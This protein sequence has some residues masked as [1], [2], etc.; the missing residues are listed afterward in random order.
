MGDEL[1]EL[2]GLD[3]V[4]ESQSDVARHLNGLV[5][6]DQRRHG[7]DAAVAGCQAWTLPQ[8]LLDR[9]SGV[10]LERRGYRP[11][12]IKGY[13]GRWGGRHRGAFRLIGVGQWRAK[14]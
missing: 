7:D 5:A 1:R 14:E 10:F 9:V 6:R 13:G 2:G 12:V 4:V 11:D 8:A 3:A